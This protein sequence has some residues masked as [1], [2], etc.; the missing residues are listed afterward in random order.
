MNLIKPGT[1]FDFVGK[2]KIAGV[3]S[4]T[5]VVAS[6]LLFFIKGPN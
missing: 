3:V 2:R 4:F 1:N 5:M 6:L